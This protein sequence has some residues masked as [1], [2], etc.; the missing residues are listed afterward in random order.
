MLVALTGWAR[1]ENRN[2]TQAAGF[3][4]H[5][6]KPVALASLVELISGRS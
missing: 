1:E 5:L 6:V 2:R 4:H 3:D